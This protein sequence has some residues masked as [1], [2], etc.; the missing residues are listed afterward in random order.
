MGRRWTNPPSRFLADIPSELLRPLDRGRGARRRSYGGFGGGAE[1]TSTRLRAW[2]DADEGAA[3]QLR[4]CGSRAWR[5]TRRPAP[6]GVRARRDGD[7]GAASGF[8]AG[9]KVRHAKFGDG[10]VGELRRLRRR[11]RDHGGVSGRPWGEASAAQLR[12]AGEAVGGAPSLSLPQ[13]GEVQGAPPSG[14]VVGV[15]PHRP[16]RG[17]ATGVGVPCGCASPCEERAGPGDHPWATT[18]VAATGVGVPCGC[19]SPSEERA[20]PG[21]HPWATTRV[22]PT[23]LGAPCGV[24]VPKRG[25]RGPRRPPLGDHK[26]RPYKEGMDSRGRG[27]D[28]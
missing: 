8:D 12:A 22:A 25:T 27:N 11:P 2:D 20:G 28:G 14:G 15:K 24:R 5:V 10:V 18:R 3:A 17:A 26:G 23:G 13:G 6:P 1:R 21:D 19:A 16:A 4:R 9:D 7:G